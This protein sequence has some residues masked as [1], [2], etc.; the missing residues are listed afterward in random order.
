MEQ[1]KLRRTNA[2]W[3]FSYTD[4]QGVG[5]VVTTCVTGKKEHLGGEDQQGAEDREETMAGVE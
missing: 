2:I 5:G 4:S 3:L 1:A